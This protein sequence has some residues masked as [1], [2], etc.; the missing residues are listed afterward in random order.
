MSQIFKTKRLNY[1]SN[2]NLDVKI[3][4]SKITH[5]LDKKIFIFICIYIYSKLVSYIV[6]QNKSN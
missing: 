1:Q 4:F 5:C 6:L 3:L 2:A